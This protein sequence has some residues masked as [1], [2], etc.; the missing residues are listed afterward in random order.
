[1]ET[2]TG[3]PDLGVVWPV[4][5][6]FLR[7]DHGDHSIFQPGSLLREAR[8]QRNLPDDTVPD[9]CLLD[10]DGNVV[11]WLQRTGRGRRSVTWACY[12]TDLWQTE[13]AGISESIPVGVIG[14]AVG[15][16]FA[17]LVAEELFASGC[18]LLVSVTSAGQIDPTLTLPATI[19]IEHAMR[20]EGTSYAYLPPEPT[21]AGEAT[22]LAAV[23][24]E[25]TRSGMAVK[26]G[27]TWTTDAPFRE[28]RAALEAA[29]AAGLQA[30]EMESAGLYAFA[31][32]R[33]RP[34]VCFALVTNQ[35]AQNGD[36]FEKGPDNGASHA[37]ALLAATARGW[38]A[39]RA[40]SR[41]ENSF[42][43]RP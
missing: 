6:S 20:G 35:L 16:P 4:P 34:V 12:H 9:V 24:N 21:V 32:A 15:A 18:A 28:T 5:A 29:A 26:R 40:A 11:R 3:S 17:V 33:G 1:M 8:R 37:L 7:T 22:L 41:G 36:D 39:L 19:L 25:L 14:N 43:V 31:Q 30:V 42:E 27:A 38:R 10:P 23:A 13:V 2:I